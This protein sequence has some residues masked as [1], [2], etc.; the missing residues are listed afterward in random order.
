MIDWSL[1]R[2]KA[3]HRPDLLE[4]EDLLACSEAFLLALKWWRAIRAST[5]LGIASA[6]PYKF[7]I[8]SQ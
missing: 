6:L 8:C 5:E 3:L 4:A 2:F 7:G 1:L